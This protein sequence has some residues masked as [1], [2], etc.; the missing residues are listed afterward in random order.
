MSSGSGHQVQHAEAMLLMQELLDIQSRALLEGNVAAMR[1]TVNLPYRRKTA[2]IDMI[3]E[4]E[5]DLAIGMQAFGASLKS[6]GVNHFIRLA[7][8][9]EFLN[10]RV[11][12][13]Y[14]TTHAL[15]NATQMVPSYENRVVLREFEGV[16]KV[17]ELASDLEAKQWPIS[18]LR[19]AGHAG[20]RMERAQHDA[21]RHWDNPLPLYQNFLD[22]LTDTTITGDFDAYIAL[23]DL[24]YTSHGNH[25]D[26]LM[27]SPSDVRPF[28][29]L[30]VGMI[31]GDTA[32]TFMRSAESAQFLGADIICGYHTSLFLKNGD[33]ALPPIK[34]RMILKHTNTG[35]KLK[36]VTNAIANP[37]YP[38]SAPEPSDALPT[39]REIQERTKSWPTSL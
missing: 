22:E 24:P 14:F 6:L 1:A 26:T 2:D 34:S 25:I 32:D 18:L 16:W 17:V 28:F 37:S 27:E 36:H 35:W 33:T 38:Y 5:A 15:R 3:I 29:D 30:T 4:S 20:V 7:T 39:H 10:D 21:R 13:G 31:R 11:I 12:E 23:C 19:V 8:D 9:A